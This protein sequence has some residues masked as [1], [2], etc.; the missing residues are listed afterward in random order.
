MMDRH[1]YNMGIIGNCAYMAHINDEADVK[2]LCW[3]YFHSSFVFG[4]LLDEEKGG[5]FYIKPKSDNYTTQQ[6]YIH[7]TNV[8]C[9][10]F[11]VDD[12]RFRVVDYAPRFKE[13]VRMFHP[14]MLFRKIEPIEGNPDIV[15]CC[16][17]VY[18]YGKVKPEPYIGSNHIRY[19]GFDKPVRLTTNIPL[20]YVLYEEPIV[21]DKEKHLVLSWGIPLEG[22]LET[23]AQRFL[24]ETINYWQNWINQ[25]PIAHYNQKTVIRSVLAL[26]LHLFQDTGAIIAAGTTSLPEYPGDGRNWDYRYCW[27]RDAYYTLQVFNNIGHFDELELY[28]NF[29]QN[30]ATKV[31]GLNFSPVYNI[32]GQTK[33][34]TEETLDLEGY[35]G[36][37]PVR[38]GN[39]AF[40]HLQYDVF[41]Q[42]LVS[43]LPIYTDERFPNKDE[44]LA[45][46]VY[47]NILN[48]IEEV[49]GKPDAGLWEFRE[50]NQRHCYTFLFHWAG[51]KS[52][53]KVAH[54][55]GDNQLA[56]KAQY[57]I[58]D[59]EANIE[60]CYDP[61]KQVYTE[62]I[63]SDDLDASL[64]QLITLSYLDPTSERAKNHLKKLEEA[65]K[66][67][68]G[69]F[70]RYKHKDDFGKPKSAFNVCAFWYV[71]ALA[72]VGRIDDAQQRFEE[73]IQYTNHLGLLSE[74]TDPED[75]SQWGNFPQAYSQVGIVNAAFRIA[76][77]LDLPDFFD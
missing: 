10:E 40:E 63:E 52:A 8:L 53:L 20:S 31:E 68:D 28:S 65:L 2:W 60:A 73:L 45:K 43:L 72:C 7:N 4:G 36:N 6:Y 74:D 9:T 55:F 75:G 64:L 76:K 42:I 77:K 32:L 56:N 71:E 33:P 25:A 3:P 22:P 13:H 11:F 26:K 18:D 67:E 62:A 51:A 38:K 54:H 41:G 50:L 70:Y 23:T 66:T 61:E 46:R 29:I 17:P 47:S 16:K 30:L 14:L 21:V 44:A 12:G 48:K 39:Q 15:V 69:L 34:V 1:T 57:I 58:K 24:D 5:A 49:M 59:A 37:K 35:K 27:L 19:L